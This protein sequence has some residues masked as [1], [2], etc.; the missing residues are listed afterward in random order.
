MDLA[1]LLNICRVAG[2]TVLYCPGRHRAIG[3]EVDTQ[4]LSMLFGARSLGLQFWAIAVCS[5]SHLGGP[6]RGPD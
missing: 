5:A 2:V 1:A 6:I 4:T 3:S